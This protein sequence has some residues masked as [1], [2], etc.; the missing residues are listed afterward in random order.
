MSLLMAYIWPLIKYHNDVSL[1]HLLL[2]GPALK[3]IIIEYVYDIYDCY[4]F[5]YMLNELE[6]I[7]SSNGT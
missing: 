7:I 2:L 3:F 1:W 6:G 4:T 5:T